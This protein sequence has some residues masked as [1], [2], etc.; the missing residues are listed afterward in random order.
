MKN[1]ILI[2][3][4]G[5]AIMV[6]LPT[7]A[8]KRVREVALVLS[9][10]T[11]VEAIR[12]YIIMDKSTAGFQ[13]LLEIKWTT[14]SILFG[15]DS[16]TMVFVLLTAILIPIC[17]LIGWDTPRVQETEYYV[18]LLV[19]EILLIGVFSVLDILGFYTFY[20][21]VLIPVFYLIGVWG[22]RKQKITAAMYFFF[23][24]LIGSV[25]MLISIIYIY[26]ITGT[27]DYQT[28]TTMELG[29]EVEKIL[30]LGF[31]AS[32]AVKIPMYP[33][34]V[35]LPLAHVEAP[36]AGS[37][38]LAG[39]LIKLGSYGMLRYV[40]VLMPTAS[41]YYSPLVYTL[42]LLGVIYASL[43]TLRQTDL[44]RIVAYSS[45]AHMGIV[46]LGIFT[47][48]TAG[49]E[50]SI[51]IQLAHG[52]VSTGL[53]IAVAIVY[54]RYHT[55]TIRYYSGVATT[56]P[57][58]S[59]LFFIL[60]M[61]NIA[62]P[63]TS[64]FIGEIVTLRGVMETSKSVAILSTIGMIL[65]GAYGIYMFNRVVFGAVTPYIE[66]APRDVNRREFNVLA[67]LAV[68]S[69]I[70]GIWPSEILEAIHGS[71]ISWII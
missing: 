69:I 25:L 28:I 18:S 67:P 7:T 36:I 48:T 49:Q 15:M 34:H 70:L 29:V 46:T 43:T 22:I 27:T 23:Y 71:V 41:E 51:Y 54:D 52:V 16:V 59:L 26:T 35:W 65:G 32:L 62:V 24:T 53:F 30:F 60:T 3:L 57:V 50:G 47:P 4:I 38:L 56:M 31:M 66:E 61:S 58:F 33:F 6:M 44:K 40:K 64:N 1:I 45:V 9:I 37:V 11:L 14:Q 19:V 55:R 13:H 42:S 5:T 68:L 21:G 8:R 10:L 17:I 2:P 12:L 63:G 39:V 20:E